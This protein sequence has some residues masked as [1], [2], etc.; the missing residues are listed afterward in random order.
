MIAA[1]VTPN[2]L[3]Q[4]P[5]YV[6]KARLFARSTFVV[7]YDTAIRL[8][9]PK[10]YGGRTRMLLQLAAL[11]HR[12]CQFLV[13]GRLGESGRFLTLDKVDMPEEIAEEVRR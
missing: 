10:Y 12:G 9:M 11:R 2:L 8:V 6:E 5:L 13:A 7:G 1:G 3:T 4:A